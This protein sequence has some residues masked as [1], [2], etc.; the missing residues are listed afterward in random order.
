ME[1]PI[2]T[3]L[4]VCEHVITDATTKRKSLINIINELRVQKV[5]VRFARLAVFTSLTN[6][7]GQVPVELRCIKV[8]AEEPIFT[9]KGAF[10]FPTPN[11]VVDCVFGLKNFGLHELGTYTFE[12]YCDGEL[13]LERRFNVRQIAS[14]PQPPPPA[15]P[16]TPIA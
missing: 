6:G 4:V 11:D 8:G 13:L 15:P 1:I 5:P 9:M 10:N 16:S 12:L 7:S 2:C 14:P 3:S